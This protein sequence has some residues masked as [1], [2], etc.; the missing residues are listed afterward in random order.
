MDITV[1]LAGPSVDRKRNTTVDRVNKNPIRI[2][3]QPGDDDAD[4]IHDLLD[5][6][7][8]KQGAKIIKGKKGLKQKQGAVGGGS[9]QSMGTFPG[10][11][12][13]NK[14]LTPC[15]LPRS[16]PFSAQ[17]SAAAGVHYAY[18]HPTSGFA[19]NPLVSHPRPGWHGPHRCAT[20]GRHAVYAGA[21]GFRLGSG[22][23]LAYIVP[24]IQKLGGRHSSRF[25]ARSLIMV[26][27]RELAI[28][29]VKVGKD[30]A[31]GAK[32]RDGETLRWALVVG[33]D[34]LEDQFKMMA[35]NPDM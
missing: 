25:G 30:L 2:E 20:C 18:P 7:K 10:R 9:F 16:H 23:T 35:A 34:S 13:K 1:A 4:Y 15:G 29:V 17:V 27:T 3:D 21:H 6:Q 32:D 33:G 24:L 26:P 12:L 8:L 5:R 11:P 22:K 31:R 19:C 28:Q 14:P